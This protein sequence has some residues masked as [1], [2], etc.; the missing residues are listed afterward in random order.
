M[1]GLL[2]RKPRW[3]LAAW[4]KWLL[5][6][7]VLGGTF[8]ARFALYP[9]L[10]VTDPVRGEYLVTEGWVPVSGLR[11]A[12][13]ILK[14][15]GYRKILTSG[16]LVED[17]WD[18]RAQVTYA[19]WGAAKLRRLGLSRDLVTAVPCLVE[20]RDRTFFSALA[21]KKWLQTNRI[22]IDRLDVLTIGPHAR[23]T[24]LLYEKAFGPGVMIGIIAAPASDYDSRQWWRSSEG[25][26]EVV[27]EGV[28]Y[29]YAR[30]FFRAP[31]AVGII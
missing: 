12:V 20:K 10:S 11:V 15:D 28:A 2:I 6:V 13:Q 22:T 7:A 27:G 24:R 14:S 4:A 31:A 17:E 26:R 1:G 29:V 21:I 19:D 8:L 9:F 5:L 16:S 25:V 18:A 30:F 3:G 23:R